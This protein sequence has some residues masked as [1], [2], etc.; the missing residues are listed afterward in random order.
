ML[1][2]IPFLS[3]VNSLTKSK[4]ADRLYEQIFDIGTYIVRQGDPGD[5]FYIIKKGKVQVQIREND[6]EKMLIRE[7]SENDGFGE[8]ALTEAH[9]IRTASII[10]TSKTVEVFTLDKMSYLELIGDM[11]PLHPDLENVD[12]VISNTDHAEVNEFAHTSLEEDFYK[13]GVIGVGGFGKV[14]LICLIKNVNRT[15]ALKCMKRVSL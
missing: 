7:L 2:R 14:E 11:Q 15:F 3:E 10:V 9:D 13:V 12:P 4:I 1:N 5:T 6:E 8:R